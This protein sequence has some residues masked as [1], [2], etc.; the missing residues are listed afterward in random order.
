MNKQS[1][2]TLLHAI[3]ALGI[4][5]ASMFVKNPASQQHAATVVNAVNG[6]MPV[7]DSLI[8]AA[9]EAQK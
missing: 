8:E 2:E 5:A 3:I 4:T 7:V 1:L 9:P 6:L